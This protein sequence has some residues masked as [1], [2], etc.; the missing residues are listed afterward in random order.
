[1]MRHVAVTEGDKVEAQM[2]FGYSVNTHGVG[3]LVKVINDIPEKET[4]ALINEYRDTYI[5]NDYDAVA[6]SIKDAAKI[7]LGLLR[8]MQENNF[9]AFTDTFE[10]LH[11]IKQLPGI[12]AQRLM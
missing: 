3:D 1:N 4:L 11:G 8:F 5:I 9:V 10:D 12:A 2:V 7:E 6:A